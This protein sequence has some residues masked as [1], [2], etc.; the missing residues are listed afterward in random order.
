MTRAEKRGPAASVSFLQDPMRMTAGDCESLRWMEEGV[1]E[2]SVQHLVGVRTRRRGWS[3]E[4]GVGAAM[5]GAA[6]EKESGIR[7]GVRR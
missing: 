5:D 6:Q 3:P 2:H 7:G 1:V 4:L